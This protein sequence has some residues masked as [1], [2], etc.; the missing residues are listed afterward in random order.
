M[1]SNYIKV[2]FVKA[3]ERV[4]ILNHLDF[5]KQYCGFPHSYKKRERDTQSI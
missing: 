1:D 5:N 4:F 3:K 2:N